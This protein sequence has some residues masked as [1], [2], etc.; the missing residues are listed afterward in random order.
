MLRL[1]SRAERSVVSTG[2][3]FA[4]IAVVI[5][6]IVGAVI[7]ITYFSG[8]NH[9][10]TSTNTSSVST[11]TLSTASSVSTPSSETTSSSSTATQSNSTSSTTSFTPVT[12]I[13]TVTSTIKKTTTSTGPT[14]YV[15]N[16]TR[17]GEGPILS[18]PM[19]TQMGTT[20]FPSDGPCCGGG[21][22]AVVV[23]NDQGNQ[24][25]W[26]GDIEPGTAWA[27]SNGTGLTVT[28]DTS[29]GGPHHEFYGDREA[30]DD[31]SI[32]GD[33]N[34]VPAN[35]TLFSVDVSM[36][37]YN[38]YSYCSQ[39]YGNGSNGCSYELT[40][41]N[42]AALAFN[43]DGSYDVVSIAEV[44]NYPCT[45]NAL[46][47]SAYTSAGGSSLL[48]TLNTVTIPNYTSSHRLTIATDRKSFIDFYVDNILLYSNTTMPISQPTG[49]PGQVEL[50]MRTSVNNETDA[51]T[52]SNFT[53]YANST[54]SAS[55]LSRQG[56][57][58]VVN[59]TNGFNA[60]S[61]ASSNG[62]ATVNVSPNPVN[63]TVSIELNG[64]IIATYN[65]TVSAGAQFQLES[66][67]K[68]TVI[69]ST[70]TSTYYTT[71]TESG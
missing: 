13:S 20:Y 31:S 40:P 14:N 47:L 32:Y 42:S 48:Q 70:L 5:I 18:S 65:V 59:G 23:Y 27:S 12:S 1:C 64:K 22:G 44:C 49:V 50:S 7:G 26:Q 63:L 52:F 28:Y 69:V 39:D 62:T 10:T 21:P 34:N 68:T 56:M 3:V 19:S 60:S 71:V 53:A 11:S 16:L 54:I 35:A 38:Y 6:I 2:V 9:S 51:V 8:V 43:V 30:F 46:Q 67:A 66:S 29:A 57:T 37:Y 15:L 4:A 58:L 17:A 45:S 61:I 33:L 55:G 25:V 36:P 24:W 41:Y